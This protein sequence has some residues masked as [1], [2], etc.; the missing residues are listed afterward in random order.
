[1]LLAILDPS[2]LCL[3]RAGCCLA[4]LSCGAESLLNDNDKRRIFKQGRD[5]V[6]D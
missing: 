6:C 1:V 3:S 2:L 5:D 4:L